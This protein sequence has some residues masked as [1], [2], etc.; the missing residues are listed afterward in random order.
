MLSWLIAAGA[1]IALAALHYF[2]ERRTSTVSLA[3]VLRAI[4]VL[5]A[6]ALLLDAPRGRAALR[7]PMVALDASASWQRGRP[8]SAWRNVLERAQGEAGGDTLWIIGD[9]LRA[10]NESRDT[11]P[12]D[13]ASRVEAV[14]N[15]ALGAGRPLVL[16]SDGEIDD[17]EMLERLLA[18]S[19]I[20]IAPASAARD[21]AILGLELPR[22][23]VGGD[24]IEVVVRLSAGGG[25][26]SAGTATIML[27]RVQLER[28]TFDS[29]A[30][31]GERD[32]RTKV[33]VPLEGGEHRTLRA[34]V[35][36]PGDITPRN[37]SLGAALDVAAAARAVF[38]STAP[39][40]DARFA[41]EV[42]RGT[43]AIAVRA[44]YRVAP[45][46]WRQEPGFTPATEADV[47]TAV[48]D[49]PIAIIHGD[50]AI[51]GAP[52]PLTSGALVLIAPAA[53]D[54]EEWYAVTAPTSPI[55]GALAGLPWDSL[56]PLAVGASPQGE[57]TALAAQRRRSTREER[58]LIAGSEQPRRIVVVTGSGYWRW[59]FRAGASTEAFAALWGGVF[60]WMASGGDDRRGAVPAASWT[61]TGDPIAWRRGARRDS[62]V[63]VQLRRS[64]E[65][66]VDTVTLRFPG[67]A[68]VAESPPLPVGEYEITVP[69]GRT[70]LVVAESREWLPR[71]ATVANGDK[72]TARASG[73]APRL[74]DVW[75]AYVIALAAVCMEWLVRRRAGLR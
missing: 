12:S 75:W 57:W 9:S 11:I 71:R 74:R 33:R 51:F 28:V 56:P 16:F 22:S 36:A 49:A 15:R 37:D 38:V 70:R 58:V 45:N 18:G 61:R 66:R 59:R 72:G 3:A 69:G 55:S 60:D 54:G 63:T 68:T 47:R 20:D 30:P 24:T 8:D 42:L 64:D 65:A 4:A 39:D 50:T 1:G 10:A 26:S 19:R 46:V 52:R 2:R 67:S 27:D 44:Y 5:F 6:V 31:F 29:L 73:L 35:S 40:Q 43:L 13:A 23:A 7:A 34:V 21:V 48:A 53:G 14:V 25:G 41:L 32:V 62:V 17:P